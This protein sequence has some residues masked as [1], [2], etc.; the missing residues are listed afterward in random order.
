MDVTLPPR[1]RLAPKAAPKS[2]NKT[3][4][5]GGKSKSSARADDG[6]GDDDDDDDTQVSRSQVRQYFHTWG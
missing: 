2:K 1:V 4:L 5:C 3:S 6:D